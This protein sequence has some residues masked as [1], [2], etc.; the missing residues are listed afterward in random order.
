[1]AHL[2]I[3]P[4]LRFFDSNGAPLV[5]GKLYSY[6]AGTSTPLATFTDKTETGTNA[7]PTILD[8]NGEAA[9]WIGANAYKFVLKDSSDLTQWTSDN[10]SFVND[11][12]IVAAKLATDSVTTVKILD[13]NVTTAKIADSAVTTV[14][15]ADSN[16]TTAKIADSN[17][18][19]A[20]IADSNVTTAKIADSNVTT[21][22]IAD[23]NVTAVKIADGAVT[24]GKI[25]DNNISTSKYADGSVTPTKRSAAIYG[26]AFALTVTTSATCAV[27]IARTGRPVLL[28]VTVLSRDSVPQE[29]ILS[30]ASTLSIYSSGAN[31]ADV[32]SGAAGTYGFSGYSYIDTSTTVASVQYDLR[33]SAGTATFGGA[34]SVIYLNVIEL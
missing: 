28:N 18:T 14:K 3:P 5:G 34:S 32:F 9:V 15:I 4:K 22:K 19:T 2:L 11:A 7:N 10:V 16:V 25:A 12:S 27:T 13:S 23:A 30:D 6:A 17:V 26:A 24:T 21:A 29:I 33:M 31:F 20:K 8:A 1:M